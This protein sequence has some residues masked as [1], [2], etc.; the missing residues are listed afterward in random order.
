[1]PQPHICSRH[2]TIPFELPASWQLSTLA[3]FDDHQM[4]P[5]IT[6]LCAAVLDNPIGTRPLRDSVSSNHTVAILVEDLTRTSPKKIILQCLLASLKQMGVGSDHIRIVMALGTHRG[7]SE[8]ELSTAFGP[9][10]VRDYTFINH[11][12]NAKDL[13]AIGRLSSGTEVKINR[14]VYEADFRIGIGSIFPHPMNG[15]GGGGKILFPGVADYTSIFEHHLRH[16]FRDRAVLGMLEGNAFYA[17][18]R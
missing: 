17:E 4:Q 15:F 14:I 6:A 13:V 5:D 11:D 3:R 10:I 8:E 1:M 12:C 7:L 2:G 16:S 18:V 9:D